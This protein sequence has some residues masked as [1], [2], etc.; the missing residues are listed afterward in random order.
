MAPTLGR[1]GTELQPD[2]LSIGNNIPVLSRHIRNH[3]LTL[4]DTKLLLGSFVSSNHT[5]F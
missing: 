4:D 1:R 3:S 2:P 5:L